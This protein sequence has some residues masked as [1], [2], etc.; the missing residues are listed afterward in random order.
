MDTTASVLPYTIGAFKTPTVRDLSSSEPY[1]HTGR[2]DTIEDVVGFYENFSAKARAGLVRNGDPQ[3]SGI[4]M[5]TNAIIPV[6]A[7]LRSLD[8]DYTDVP[9]PCLLF[10]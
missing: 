8:E 10:P 9:C 5:D 7:F 3:L 2:M 4:F 1:L 6:A